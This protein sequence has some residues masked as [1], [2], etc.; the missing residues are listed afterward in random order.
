MEQ[1]ELNE[2][3]T[4]EEML[5]STDKPAINNPA[6]PPDSM[7]PQDVAKFID[8]TMLKPEAT[9]E[10]FDK[11][12]D[13]A[14]T[15]RFK[16]VCV[17]SCRVAY[18]A[19]KLRGTGINVCSVIGFPLGAMDSRAKAFET[20]TAV[21]NGAV[22]ID[23]VI[24]V[25]ALKERNLKLVEEDIKAVRRAARGTT[26]LKV[27]IETSLL[28]EEEKVLA[29]GISKKAGADFVKTCTGFAG[30]GAT[31]EDIALMRSIVGPGMGVKASGGVRDYDK[32]IMLIGAG[33]N[34]LGC[35]SSVAVVTGVR[36]NT[37][38]SY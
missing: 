8:H 35:V 9:M 2:K 36:G 37:Q 1:K 33:A 28:T 13:E 26:V 12:C 3:N 38:G 22:E 20:K 11:L 18:V 19:E 5:K 14:L 34:R 31:A 15:Y 7:A 30:G 6:V 21:K 27:I 23:M 25:G 24:N 16:S 29:C 10:A 4:S 32:A 17:N